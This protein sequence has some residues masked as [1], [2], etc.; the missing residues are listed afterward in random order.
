MIEDLERE[1]P[2]ISRLGLARPRVSCEPILPA[3]LSALGAGFVAGGIVGIL[4]DVLWPVLV[5]PTQPHPEWLIPFAVTRAAQLVAVGAV[6][7]RVG[8]VATLALCVGYEA[9]FV[10]AGLPG[11]IAICDRLGPSPEFPCSPSAPAAMVVGTW[12]TWVAIAVGALGSRRL[13]PSATPGSN[14]LLRAAG[15]FTLIVSVAGAAFGLLEMFVLHDVLAPVDHDPQGIGLS[16]QVGLSTTWLVIELVAGLAAGV[17][18]RRAPP[19]AVV[20][21]ALVVAYGIGLG[22]SQLRYGLAAVPNATLGQAYLMSN[23]VLAPAAG[24]LGIAM[25]RLVAGRG[26]G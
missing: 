2:E 18:L 9:A 26:S 13:L 19:A 21:L 16:V 3:F 15:A 6:A 10:L 17:L 20:L 14:T 11:R 7:L 8:G 23:L 12:P 24:V 1:F 22:L 25:G 4:V 5:P